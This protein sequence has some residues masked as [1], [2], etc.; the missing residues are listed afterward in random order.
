MRKRGKFKIDKLIPERSEGGNKDPEGTQ[1]QSKNHQIGGKKA[2]GAEKT[3][4][5]VTE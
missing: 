2:L 3:R 1:I 5:K 4:K